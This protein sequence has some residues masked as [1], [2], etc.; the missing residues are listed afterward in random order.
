MKKEI[1]V[2]ELPEEEMIANL[3][4]EEQ[5][6]KAIL[7]AHWL[8]WLAL[9]AI[10]LASV[11]W[12]VW[13]VM[14]L[15]PKTTLEDIRKENLRKATEY[16]KYFSGEVVRLQEK[17]RLA[18]VEYDKWKWCVSANSVKWEVKDCFIFNNK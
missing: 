13:L 11:V 10:I 5:L 15:L 9:V 3:E 7:K 17:L 14:S 6:E 16:T 18:E 12:L 8:R 2:R 1:P 4:Q